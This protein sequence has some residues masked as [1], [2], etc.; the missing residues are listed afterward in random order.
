MKYLQIS[1]VLPDGERL[2]GNKIEHTDETETQ[3]REFTS[4]IAV[5]GSLTLDTPSGWFLIPESLL[6]RSYVQVRI[7][8]KN[9]DGS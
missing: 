9:D 8:E 3:A 7:W 1:V 6:Q 4:Q 2:I 5:R